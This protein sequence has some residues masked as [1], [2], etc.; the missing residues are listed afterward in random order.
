MRYFSCLLIFGH[1]LLKK[2]NLV[3]RLRAL[4]SFLSFS[5][6]Y[7]P[8][9]HHGVKDT[10]TELRSRFWIPQGRSLVRQFISR[11]LVCR[12]YASSCNKAP[13]PPPLPDYRVRESNP[14]TAIG[15]DYI[16]W[17]FGNQTSC[18]H[19]IPHHTYTN[20]GVQ[21]TH[22]THSGKAWVYLFTCCT[23]H[24]VHFELVTDLSPLS[25]I[26][27]LRDLF[28][29]EEFL[30][31]ISRTTVQ[32]L[33]LLLRNSRRYWITLRSNTSCLMSM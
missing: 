15:V 10:L 31:I 8:N 5:F 33:R 9:S 14:F 2:Y 1:S 7:C 32:L 21:N 26:R 23:S 6:T 20:Q 18:T 25:F 22:T 29:D 16:C 11:C 19:P 12:R 28:P 27:C 24:A 13:P 3:A 30:L 17:S 4:S